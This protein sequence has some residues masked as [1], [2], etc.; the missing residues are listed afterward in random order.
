MQTIIQD[1][2]FA[3]RQMRSSKALAFL[4]VLTLSL[5]IGSNAA[6]FAVMESVLFR[7]LPYANTSHLAYI[8]PSPDESGF[9]STSWLNYRDLQEQAKVFGKIAGYSEDVTI[10]ETA[11]GIQSVAAPHLTPNT[12]A[13]LGVQPLLGRTFTTAEGLPGGPAMAVLSEGLWR[14][15]FGADPSVLG[16]QVKIGGKLY[17]VIGVMPAR[18]HFPEGVGPTINDGLWLPLQPS[19]TMLQN[20]SYR[21]LHV[22]AERNAAATLPEAQAELKTISRHMRE[23]YPK[24][25]EG[26]DFSATPYRELV[27]ASVRSAFYALLGALALVLFIGCANVSN[28]LL[29]RALGRRQE[30]GAR[31]ALGASRS[32][33]VQQ[34][35]TEGAVLSV[36]G[37]AFGIAF[38]KAALLLVGKLPEGT[39]PRSDAIAMHWDILAAL[40]LVATLTTLLSSLLPVLLVARTDPQSILQ[41]YSR[42]LGGGS[43]NSRFSKWLV[44]AE[45][46]LST[47]LLIGTGLLF[48]TLWNLEHAQLGF[49]QSRVT[50]F[51]ALSS[52]SSGSIDAAEPSSDTAAA[53]VSVATQV[54]APVLER[55]RQQPGTDGAALVTTPPLSGMDMG[56]RF[57]I[58]GEPKDLSGNRNARVSAVSSDYA[59]VLGIPILRGRMITDSDIASAP[60]VVVINQSLAKR[61]FENIDPIGK[62]LD[63]G[64]KQTGMVTPYT[65]V[66]VLGD[67]ADDQVGVSVH[68]FVL[69]PYEQVPVTSPFYEALL[70][71]V[72]SFVVKSKVDIPIA[73]EMRAIFRESAQGCALQDFKTMQQVIDDS[74]F[75]QRL[76][77]SLTA[78]FAGLAILMLITGLYGVLAQLVRYRRHEIAI[79]MAMGATRGSIA[80]IILRQAGILIGLG[81]VAG[82][83]A[84]MLV[85]H[86]LASFLYQVKMVDGLTYL[87]VVVLSILIGLTA[88]L[89]P[90]IRAAS[91]QPMEA[92]RQD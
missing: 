49:E 45:V 37:C 26:L 58:V 44:V 7:P 41:E 14:Q 6:M 3:F 73:A 72:V 5:G 61:F 89:L 39:I 30:F 50:T 29:A 47:I 18:F 12:F 90:S 38:A 48:H 65:I 56:A 27:T 64:G 40:A 1:L 34:L 20:R 22:V 54:Y 4:A 86:L 67:A 9:S 28:L 70:K 15:Q 33:L 32:R 77:L 63:L 81:L 66:G 52:D 91:I 42:G 68:P 59:R 13:M 75:S 85:G 80:R 31:V 71:T 60:F 16:R 23:T 83:S 35:L 25:T 21:S 11:R 79:R 84:A 87:G 2:Y 57:D 88:S 36:L 19:P 17:V 82:L 92:L 76:G 10:L 62:Q 43:G 69:I 46:S 51:S 8:S 78:G 24:G 55:I 53:P 74:L